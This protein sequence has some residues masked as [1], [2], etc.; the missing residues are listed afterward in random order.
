M[1]KSVG[2]ECCHHSNLIELSQVPV[3]IFINHYSCMLCCCLLGM[4]N[5]EIFYSAGKSQATKK[6]TKLARKLQLPDINKIR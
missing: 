2:G 3:S 5:I 6:Q 4:N 1:T